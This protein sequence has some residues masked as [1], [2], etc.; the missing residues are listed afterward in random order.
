MICFQRR[1]DED[2]PGC[3]GTAVDTEDY[4]VNPWLPNQLII[5]GDEDE[6]YFPLGR[7]EG[8]CDSDSDCAEG[9]TCFQRDGKEA[10]PGCNGEGDS[11]SDYC[12]GDLS[13]TP[14]PTP[15]APTP[16]IPGEATVYQNG[17]VLSTGLTSR[18]IATK[19]QRVPL[20]TGG[21]SDDD[22]H[23]KP[24][25]AAVFA[26][27]DGGWVYASNSESSSNGGVGAIYFNSDG[28]VIDYRRLLSGTSRNCGVG[29]TYWGTL[30]TCEETDGGQVWE[31]DPWDNSAPRET[32]MGGDGANYESAAY[33]ARDPTRPVFYITTDE[34]DGA[35]VRY[36]P[37]QA[38]VQYAIANDDYSNLLH[39]NGGEHHYLEIVDGSNYRWTTSL[40]AGQASAGTHFQ[41]G[42]GIDVR[43]G[44]IYFTA[45]VQ[46]YLY[47]F[48]ID[49]LTYERS[50][51]E[52][53]A[54][55]NQTDQ[56][57]RVLD[58]SNGDTDGI[59]Y[60]CEDGGDHCGVHG[61]DSDGNY[62]TIL[63]NE[64]AEF[65]GE[66]T[67]LAFSPDGIFMYVAFQN[68]GHIFEIRRTDGLPFHGE[69]L[70][71]K[72]HG[73]DTNDHRFADAR[74]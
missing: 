16:Y 12:Y 19:D 25:G 45:K 49:N 74:E 54:F 39:A 70:D 14:A 50:S 31:V 58:F 40:S 66:T 63:D 62:F 30:M 10:V 7:C 1:D 17:L 73:D 29:K 22:F 71:I 67:G 46:K 59:L 21:F 52:Q 41:N 33:D 5:M 48:D 20:D 64:G 11:G 72:Y 68:P 3:S 43:D 53:G 24:D 23:T 47:I 38:A 34:S 9:L 13:P 6:G 37:A 56:V 61:R 69:K 44:K 65:S 18:I 26:G 51:T 42:E 55:D 8:D 36:T 32:K 4:C 28:E 2:V 35:F 27:E 57:A 15:P 60:F